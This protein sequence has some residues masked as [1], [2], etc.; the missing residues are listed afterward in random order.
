MRAPIADIAPAFVATAHRVVWA[1]TA[2]VDPDGRP[3]TRI[4]HPLWT[5]GDRA[6]TGIVATS[7]LSPKAAHLAANPHVALTY[8]DAAT[9]DTATALC[10]ATWDDSREGRADGWRTLAEGPEPVGYD[11]SIIPGWDSPD[12]PGFGILRLTPWRLE[13]FPGTLLLTGQGDRLTWTAEA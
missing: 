11:P 5:I 7:P 8:W 3:W 6:L 4:L 10:T 12:A 1:T 13:V 9:Q 2:T